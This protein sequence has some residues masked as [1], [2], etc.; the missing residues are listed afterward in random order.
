MV[1]RSSNSGV[2]ESPLSEKGSFSFSWYFHILIATLVLVSVFFST[3]A[4][5]S[6]EFL[7][8]EFSLKYTITALSVLVVASVI[9]KDKSVTVLCALLVLVIITGYCIL[10]EPPLLPIAVLL[11]VVQLLIWIYVRD[12]LAT[13]SHLV[14]FYTWGILYTT[15]SIY[16]R[17]LTVHSITRQFFVFTVSAI[18]TPIFLALSNIAPYQHLAIPTTRVFSTM[19]RALRVVSSVKSALSSVVRSLASRVE[20]SWRLSSVKFKHTLLGVLLGKLALAERALRGLLPTLE[21][22]AAD[23]LG[24]ITDRLVEFTRNLEDVIIE[25]IRSELVEAIR[26]LHHVFEYSLAT[27]SLVLGL[28]IL[29]ALLIYA[30]TVP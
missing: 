13:H 18:T 20:I 9:Y 26:K 28:L 29:L 16:S 3:L 7:Y 27:V 4:G 6:G 23:K 25:K 2:V 21:E 10:L 14:Y 30:L 24:N 11:Y 17:A 19:S 5:V 8:F 1:M 22:F 15:T 12:F